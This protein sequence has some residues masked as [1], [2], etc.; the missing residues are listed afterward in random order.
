MFGIFCNNKLVKKPICLVKISR[1]FVKISE[2]LVK[3]PEIF[4]K[5]LRF[6]GKIFN[7]FGKRNKHDV[8][9]ISPRLTQRT[10]LDQSIVIIPR[11]RQPLISFRHVLLNVCQCSVTYY[12]WL[13]TFDSAFPKVSPGST[14]TEMCGNILSMIGSTVD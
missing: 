4:V 3:N 8:F 12:S 10:P 7:I 14:Q 5:N 1:Y 9:E 6:F 11:P 2:F 13:I